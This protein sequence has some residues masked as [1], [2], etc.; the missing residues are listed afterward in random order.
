MSKRRLG[1]SG[2][3]KGKSRGARRFN[4]R[5]VAEHR[6]NA[7]TVKESSEAEKGAREPMRSWSLQR[8]CPGC[9]RK[10]IKRYREANAKLFR[11]KSRRCGIVFHAPYMIGT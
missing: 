8:E 10:N 1:I 5:R 2:L 7:V 3:L 6:R 4:R 11:C 9:H